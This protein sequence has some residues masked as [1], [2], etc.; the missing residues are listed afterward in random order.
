M[1]SI[2]HDS[3]KRIQDEFIV[4]GLKRLPFEPFMLY[5]RGMEP[6]GSDIKHKSGVRSFQFDLS[7]LSDGVKCAFQGCKSSCLFCYI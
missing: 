2:L 5:F 1:S 6:T 7:R 4:K 3:N